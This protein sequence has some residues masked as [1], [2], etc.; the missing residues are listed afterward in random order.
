MKEFLEE[1][2]GMKK[3]IAIDGPAGAGKST[4][5]KGL[6]KE[7]SYIYIDT[8]AMYRAVAYQALKQGIAADDAQALT[9]LAAESEID[10]RVEGGENRILLNG[11]DVTA[12][13]RLPEVGAMAS[14]V[15]AIGG[16]REHLVAQ[17]RRLAARGNVVMDGR[18]IGTVVLPDADCKIYLTASLDERVMRRY[19]E[20]KAKGLDTTPDEVKNDIETRDYRDSHR[21]NSPLRQ[22]DDAV[23]LDSTGLGIDEVLAKVRELAQD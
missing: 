17:Q 23:Y 18:D 4:I 7:L 13:I 1:N 16:V 14:P 8:G 5:A 10:M 15:S 12:E 20:L 19:T 11:E 2:G 6:A 21:E 9:K 3:V 22:A